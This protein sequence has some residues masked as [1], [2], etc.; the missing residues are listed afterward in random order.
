MQISRI[1]PESDIFLE[2][3]E[4]IF[5]G[6]RFALRAT[7]IRRGHSFFLRQSDLSQTLAVSLPTVPLLPGTTASSRYLGS[8]ISF[9][10]SGVVSRSLIDGDR[11]IVIY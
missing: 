4:P 3:R 9:N 6:H 5:L 8:A 11:G 2:L 1:S 10:E 7:P